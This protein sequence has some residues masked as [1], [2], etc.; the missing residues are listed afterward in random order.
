MTIGNISNNIRFAPGYQCAQLIAL[1]PIISGNRPTLYIAES[2]GIE[3]HHE[4]E[5]FRGWSRSVVHAVIR[6]VMTP[7]ESV[8]K[9]GVRMACADG[10]ERLCFP[11]LCEY[12]GDMPEQW[13]LT[14]LVQPACTKCLYR[15][16]PDANDPRYQRRN[17]VN[18]LNKELANNHPRTDAH[19]LE[20]RARCNDS[21]PLRALGYHPQHPFSTNYPFG[22]GIIDAVG[23]DLLHQISKCFMDYLIKAWIWKLMKITWKGRGFSKTQLKM[24]FDS[25]F[26]LMP[27][28]TGIRRFEHGVLTKTH[29]WTVHE[30]KEI[31][32]VII[33][34]LIGLCPAE[35]IH[36]VMQYLDIHRLAHYSCHTDE[37]LAWLENAVDQFF[38]QLKS[39]NGPFIKYSLVSPESE[40]QKIHYQRHY[41]NTVREKGALPSSSTDRTEP[42]HKLLKDAWRRSNKGKD[43][44]EFVLKEHTT[45]SAFQ[46]HI[47]SF[48]PGE[49]SENAELEH[50]APDDARIPGFL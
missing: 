13:L 10:A 42:L 28:Y 41:A 33:G 39:P 14:C 20:Q 24:E 4:T 37:S 44:I 45:L 17:A 3:T 8:M 34:A 46:S 2:S 32:K 15:G 21:V 43:S 23:P 22:T 11:L 29:A 7:I 50:L 12:I 9:N 36:L 48:D 40:T 30:Y 49:V 31:M 19:A 27:G 35:G 6:D 18:K 47:D 1:I 25:R 16:T 26:A 5:E 38:E